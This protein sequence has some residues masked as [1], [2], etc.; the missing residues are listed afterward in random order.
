M[1]DAIISIARQTVRD[2]LFREYI[3]IQT[4]I[5]ESAT[6][7]LDESNIEIIDIL[8]RKG[9]VRVAVNH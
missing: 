1:G 8:F 4:I 7:K 9:W 3:D 5:I 6:K 2:I